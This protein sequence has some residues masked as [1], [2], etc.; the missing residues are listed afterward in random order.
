LRD[1]F[2]RSAPTSSKFSSTN[3]CRIASAFSASSGD[4]EPGE[5]IPLSFLMNENVWEK[6]FFVFYCFRIEDKQEMRLPIG[7]QNHFDPG[8]SL[9]K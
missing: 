5:R 2:A 8:T 6:I 9:Q 7:F 4:T 3:F 1:S